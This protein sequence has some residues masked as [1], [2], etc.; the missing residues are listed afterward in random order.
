MRVSYKHKGRTYKYTD[1]QLLN[2]RRGPE[3]IQSECGTGGLNSKYQEEHEVLLP[4][5]RIRHLHSTYVRDR[6]YY[7]NIG[8]VMKTLGYGNK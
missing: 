5:K 1:C 8:L 4:F 6:S 3:V 7:D 2:C